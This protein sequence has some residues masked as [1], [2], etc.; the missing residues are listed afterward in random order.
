MPIFQV[1]DYGLV[2]DPY[3]AV[4]ERTE[5]LAKLASELISPAASQISAGKIPVQQWL[6][7]RP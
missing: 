5:E 1:V 7:A 4:P 6:G 2:A 3:Q